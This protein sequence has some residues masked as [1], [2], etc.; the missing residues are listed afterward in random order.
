MAKD[1]DQ[2]L[3]EIIAKEGSLSPEETILFVKQLKKDRRY[4]RDVY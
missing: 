2:A 3:H 4:Q 1:V